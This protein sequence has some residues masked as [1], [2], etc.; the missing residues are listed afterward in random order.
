MPQY[1]EIEIEDMTYDPKTLTYS[2]P[3]PCGDRFKVSLE[4]LWEGDDIA[5]CQS[6]TLYIQ[7][8]YEKDNLP[9]L[10]DG[11]DD[12]GDDNTDGIE[13]KDDVK[14]HDD[15]ENHEEK[16]EDNTDEKDD[17][18]MGKLSLRSSTVES[19]LQ[20]NNPAVAA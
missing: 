13:D 6:C 4:D 17:L 18:G 3:C 9:P 7:V 2:Y 14:H 12:D 1:D 11:D 5:D 16:K 20:Q 10:P 8:I 19:E 15:Q